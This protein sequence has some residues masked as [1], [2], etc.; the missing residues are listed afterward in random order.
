MLSK[1]FIKS[2]ILL[3]T[4]LVLIVKKPRGSLYIYINYR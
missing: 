2:S 4:S 1:G 3:Y